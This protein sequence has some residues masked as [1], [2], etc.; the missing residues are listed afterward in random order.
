LA[1][2]DETKPSTMRATNTWE[3]TNT[4]T[5]NAKCKQTHPK[6]KKIKHKGVE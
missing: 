1:S 2:T 6:H 4:K 3:E 5:K